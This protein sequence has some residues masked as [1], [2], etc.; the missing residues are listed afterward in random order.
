[1]EKKMADALE[2]AKK[3]AKKGKTKEKADERKG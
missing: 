2:V 3:K 1:M